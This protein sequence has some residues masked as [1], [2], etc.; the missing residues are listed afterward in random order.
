M[1]RGTPAS[2]GLLTD[3]QVQTPPMFSDACLLK[4]SWLTKYT[5][6]NQLFRYYTA[7]FFY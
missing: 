6:F 5:K 2:N 3:K 1:K 4:I 7:I